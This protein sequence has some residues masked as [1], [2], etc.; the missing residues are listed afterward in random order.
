MEGSPEAGVADSG[1]V[2]GSGP[3]EGRVS[4]DEAGAGED[5]DG[6]APGAPPGTS[7]EAELEGAGE[8][9]FATADADGAAGALEEAA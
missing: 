6:D 8:S 4:E 9:P 3:S 5:A 1:V 2:A 7:S